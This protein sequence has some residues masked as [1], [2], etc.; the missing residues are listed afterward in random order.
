[1]DY[2]TGLMS[3]FFRYSLAQTFLLVALAAFAIAMATDFWRHHFHVTSNHPAL[4]VS[5]DGN[6]LAMKSSRSIQNRIRPD[7]SRSHPIN[8]SSRQADVL[9][10][11]P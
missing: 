3:R 1:M 2:R 8:V 6:S 9:N 11:N 7:V 4:T 10:Y 5:P